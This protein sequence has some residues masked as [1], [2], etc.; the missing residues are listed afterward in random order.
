[1]LARFARRDPA[2]GV[3]GQQLTDEVLKRREGK[4]TG[5][6]E[7]GTPKFR[8]GI[9]DKTAQGDHAAAMESEQRVGLRVQNSGFIGCQGRTAHR[10]NAIVMERRRAHAKATK[11]ARTGQAEEE[12]AQVVCTR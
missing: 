10:D 11:R 9:R 7:R 8:L 2:V 3:H 5:K 4:D 1:M 6:N 12:A